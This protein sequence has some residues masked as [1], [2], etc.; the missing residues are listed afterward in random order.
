VAGAKGRQRYH[1]LMPIVMKFGNF[2]ILAVQACIRIAKKTINI[3]R[4]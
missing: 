1:L 3:V 2:N 4:R